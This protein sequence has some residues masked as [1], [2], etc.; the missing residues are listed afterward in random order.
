[1][2]K[3]LK[4][5]I[6]DE[7][8]AALILAMILMSVLAV[9]A[10]TSAAMT[11]TEYKIVGNERIVQ[12]NF[13]LAESAARQGLERLESTD[14]DTLEDI[15][16]QTWL[17]KVGDGVD[18]SDTDNWGSSNSADG[19]IENSDYAVRQVGVYRY[20]S[21]DMTNSSTLYEFASYGYGHTSGGKV[22]VEIG[23]RV[24]Y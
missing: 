15:D 2:K 17:T 22:L 14:A 9:L 13:N 8:G 6:D 21:L 19:Y 1:M 20:T 11:S 5:S 23:Y 3:I 7:N 18:M 4:K 24:R 10:M 12:D 16:N